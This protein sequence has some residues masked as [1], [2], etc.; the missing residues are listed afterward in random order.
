MSLNEIE[1]YFRASDKEIYKVIA[2]QGAEPSKP[3]VA[4]FESRI[5]SVS[6]LS[7]ESSPFIRLG[8]VSGGEGGT[9]AACARI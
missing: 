6:L 5:G 1:R 2:Q 4:A 7:F 9:L 8:V 3:D